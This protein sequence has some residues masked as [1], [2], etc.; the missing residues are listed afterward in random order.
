MTIQPFFH[1]PLHLA[2]TLVGRVEIEH[3]CYALSMMLTIMEFSLNEPREMTAEGL[4]RYFYL[5][6]LPTWHTA[7][8]FIAQILAETQLWAESLRRKP[9][10]VELVDVLRFCNRC[11]LARVLLPDFAYLYVQ[12]LIVDGDGSRQSERQWQA[13]AQAHVCRDDLR[14]A[15]E[16]SRP[17][18]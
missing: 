6:G 4:H 2:F 1:D 14:E 17:L 13:A 7:R 9:V 8:P 3:L 15:Y 10:S 5:S 12:W 11:G 18:A 16:R